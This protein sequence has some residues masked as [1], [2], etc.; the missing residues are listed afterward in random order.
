METPACTLELPKEYGFQ[1][2]PV[3]PELCVKEPRSQ[4]YPTCRPSVLKTLSSPVF[5]SSLLI[6]AD[7]F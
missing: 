7:E 3:T 6:T 4:A 2:S 5:L 1:V